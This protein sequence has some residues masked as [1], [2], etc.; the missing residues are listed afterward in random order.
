MVAALG[1]EGYPQGGPLLRSQFESEKLG[2][3]FSVGWVGADRDSELLQML[4]LS[5]ADS[6]K[7]LKPL[8]WLDR[9]QKGSEELMH[10]HSAVPFEEVYV[11]AGIEGGVEVG[12]GPAGAF[13][14][15]SGQAS[16]VYP[17]GIE[18]RGSM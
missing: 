5:L 11:Q 1:G 7:G 13:T 18:A 9:V 17:L 10:P 15:L 12:I 14:A 2:R 16:P 3:E 8:V 6:L 4:T